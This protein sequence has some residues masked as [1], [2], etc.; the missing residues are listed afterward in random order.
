MSPGSM[1]V[2]LARIVQNK[3]LS[4]SEAMLK[5]G[6]FLFWGQP[7]LLQDGYVQSQLQRPRRLTLPHPI[8]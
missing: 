4:L 2:R 5:K 8:F 6:P 1:H 7:L 3:L